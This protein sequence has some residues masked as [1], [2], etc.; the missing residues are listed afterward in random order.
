MA[1]LVT[2]PSARPEGLF[3]APDWS[4]VG[5]ILAI[6]GSFLLANA[7]LFRDP[8]A[9]VREHFGQNRIQL[10]TIREFIFHRVQMT[11]G[12]GFLMTGFALQLLGRV[13]PP[14]A[15][16][17]PMFPILW[18]GG[19]VLLAIAMEVVGWWWS[20]RAFR[21][22]VVQYFRANPP[23]FATDMGTVREVGELFGVKPDA[24]ETVQ[25]YAARVRQAMGL[26]PVRPRESFADLLEPAGGAGV[27]T[28]SEALEPALEDE[29]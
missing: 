4:S 29:G 21:R 12:F 3:G 27:A 19:I 22:Y 28:R 18:I 6:V 2:G 1:I 23:D 26:T 15:G 13:L 8:K 7:I 24:N 20:Q 14:A 17:E 16:A 10:R 5:L 9:L 11:L 25:S